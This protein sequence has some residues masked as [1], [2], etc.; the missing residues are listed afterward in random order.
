MTGSSPEITSLNTSHPP[1]TALAHNVCTPSPTLLTR[2]RR[3]A[4]PQRNG[5]PTSPLALHQTHSHAKQTRTERKRERDTDIRPEFRGN[6]AG[7]LEHAIDPGECD[8]RHC[9]TPLAIQRSNRTLALD[10]THSHAKKTRAERKRERDTHIGA[11]Q[12]SNRTS[13]SQNGRKRNSRH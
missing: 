8:L 9:F 5:P 6:E 4:A 1:A 12:S 7:L 2:I 10:Q 13:I 3:G 11:E